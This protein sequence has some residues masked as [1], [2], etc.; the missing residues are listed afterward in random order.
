MITGQE[1]KVTFEQVHMS[2]GNLVE[3]ST[4]DLELARQFIKCRA[5]NEQILQIILSLSI[6]D[7]IPGML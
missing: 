3:A 1:L 6:F 5:N 7:Q 2:L 4:E